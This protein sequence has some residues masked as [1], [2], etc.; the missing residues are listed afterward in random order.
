MRD[1]LTGTW[2]GK[3]W[4]RIVDE[5]SS[6]AT[7]PRAAWAAL[8]DVD[9]FKR[10]NG[11]NGH[12]EGDHVLVKLA[13]FLLS[14]ER[15]EHAQALRTGGGEFALVA[16]QDTDGSGDGQVTCERILMWTRESLTPDQPVHCGDAHCVGPTRLTVSIALGRIEP[17][18]SPTSLRERLGMTL[19]EAKRAGRDRVV[20]G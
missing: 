4:P 20:S 5:I 3:E 7:D 19:L 1:R 12:V 18:E 9:H 13:S 2:S 8:I 15:D 17:G 10:F 6:Q 11:H 16:H 14:L